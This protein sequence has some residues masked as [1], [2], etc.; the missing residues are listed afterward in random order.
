[1]GEWLTKT[2][3]GLPKKIEEYVPLIGDKAVKLFS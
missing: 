2:E 3:K 1:M